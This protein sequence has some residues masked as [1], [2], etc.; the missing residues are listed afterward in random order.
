[1]NKNNNKN[2]NGSL[3]EE[4]ETTKERSF[5]PL[6]L[7]PRHI[8]DHEGV[9]F[10]YTVDIYK[11]ILG[12]FFGGMLAGM[13]GVGGGVIFVPV[14]L[15]CGFPIHLAVATST[16]LI[17]FTSTSSTV[18]KMVSGGAFNI[19]AILIIGIGAI[20]GSNIGARLI[21]RVKAMKLELGLWAIIFASGLSTI[22]RT[23]YS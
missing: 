3:V 7:S 15:M 6:V 16:L 4:E 2:S 20:I 10:K 11:G 5:P 21:R 17:V 12:I 19:E 23:I 1:N 8:V 9:E 22:L 13:I 18:T 14:L